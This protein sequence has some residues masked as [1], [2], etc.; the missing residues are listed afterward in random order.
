ME[1]IPFDAEL[2]KSGKYDV[3]TRDDSKVL[4]LLVHDANVKFPVSVLIKDFSYPISFDLMGR[5]NANE[6]QS[7]R[8]LF[9]ILKKRKVWIAI[10]KERLG[11]DKFYI[12][13]QAYGT[14]K[15]LIDDAAINGWYIVELELP[16]DCD[17]KDE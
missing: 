17:V 10:R 2:W 3:V 14:E 13:S 8:D 6:G 4:S 16:D 7:N 9:L 12:T 15:E 5:E 11:T 1:K